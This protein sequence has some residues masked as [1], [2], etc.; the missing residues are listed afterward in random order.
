MADIR[1]SARKAEIL[2]YNG[3]KYCKRNGKSMESQKTTSWRCIKYLT[4]EK[5]GAT[6]STKYVDGT[7]MMTSIH[8][9]HTHDPDKVNY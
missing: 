2:H 9:E 7:V 1:L 4:K 6:V 3:F 5:C 8:S